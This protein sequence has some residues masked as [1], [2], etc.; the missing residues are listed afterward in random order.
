M[1]SSFTWLDHSESDRRRAL[2]VID[3]FR[4]KGTLDE[5]GIGTVRDALADTLFP[6]ISTLQ[7]RAKY[8]LFIPWIYKTIET[9]KINSNDVFR[10]ARQG[11]IDLI[12]QLLESSDTDGVIGK[13][14]KDNLQRLPSSVYWS[15]L[16]KFGIRIF[17]G[18]INHYHHSLNGNYRRRQNS[19]TSAEEGVVDPFQ[20]Q[21]NWHEGLPPVPKNFPLGASMILSGSEAEYLRQ[22]FMTNV[23]RTLIAF[24]VD[25]GELCDWVEY[26]WQ[27]PQL[28]QF[29]N[30]IRIQ[31]HHAELFS[32]I[33][34]GASLLYY[35]MLAEKR[36]STRTEGTSHSDNRVGES[37]KLFSNWFDEVNDSR[38]SFEQW[39]DSQSDFWDLVRSK[40]PNVPIRTE[41]FIKSWIRIVREANK[42]ETLVDNEI[43]RICIQSREDFLK[44]PRARLSN[45]R[46]LEMWNGDV[47]AQRLSYRWAQVERI[48]R[49]I[50]QG[51]NGSRDSAGT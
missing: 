2:D 51:L 17:K 25:Q 18:S 21:K 38:Q 46:A 39:C 6:G 28:G 12:H 10:I 47:G 4:E 50:L 48:T 16:G 22:R 49:D 26:P 36:A 41:Q 11:E 15:G 44:R 34:L 35:L 20:P 1:A 7:T 40:N 31:L 32:L 30:R 33:M 5:L 45:A 23:P 29:S 19:R 24:L 3:Q 14:A 37:R 9:K 8:L 27:H 13:E 42:F 43:T